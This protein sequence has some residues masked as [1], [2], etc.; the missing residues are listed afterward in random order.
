MTVKD[1]HMYCSGNLEVYLD[2]EDNLLFVLDYSGNQ[3]EKNFRLYEQNQDRSVLSFWPGENCDGRY[4][5]Y[6]MVL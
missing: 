1:V 4:V 5:L 6:V 2:C 3:V